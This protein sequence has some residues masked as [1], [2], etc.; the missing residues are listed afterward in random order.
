M[1]ELAVF[2]K[3]MLLFVII[4]KLADFLVL[5]FVRISHGLMCLWIPL[6]TPTMPCVKYFRLC[7]VDHGRL[8]AELDAGKS[9]SND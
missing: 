1:T 8:S 2:V 5:I 4:T 7:D 3:N 9:T 6:T